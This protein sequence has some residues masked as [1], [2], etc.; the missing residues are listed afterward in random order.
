M[1]RRGAC[2]AGFTRPTERFGLRATLAEV[3]N[4]H[5]R[6]GTKCKQCLYNEQ[7]LCLGGGQCNTHTPRLV[8][9]LNSF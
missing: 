3:A 6:T 5:L 4:I 7:I 8:S 9:F 2:V 1:G